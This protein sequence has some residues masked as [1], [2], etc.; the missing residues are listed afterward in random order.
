[1]RLLAYLCALSSLGNLSTV[2]SIFTRLG[3]QSQQSILLPKGWTLVLGKGVQTAIVPSDIF[4]R[5]SVPAPT[6]LQ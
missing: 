2:K 3:Q 1:M 5:K 6:I 4:A